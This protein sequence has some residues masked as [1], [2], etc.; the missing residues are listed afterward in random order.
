MVTV[1]VTMRSGEVKI[2]DGAR[3]DALFWSLPAFDKFV[4]PYLT[5]VAGSVYAAEQRELYRRGRSPLANSK[6]IPHWRGS[7]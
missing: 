3:F 1:T 4:A 6:P 5:S 7:L 2:Y